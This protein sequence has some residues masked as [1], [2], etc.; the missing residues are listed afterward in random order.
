MISCYQRIPLQVVGDGVS[1]ITMPPRKQR[2]FDEEG[3][4]SLTFKIQEWYKVSRK[5]LDLQNV[6]P[7][8]QRCRYLTFPIYPWWKSKSSPY[9]I[10]AHWKG[11]SVAPLAI[12]L[13]TCGVDIACID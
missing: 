10:H 12:W 11:L 2:Y 7:V 13:K 3:R 4:K 6:L 5:G 8:G 1:T 9:R